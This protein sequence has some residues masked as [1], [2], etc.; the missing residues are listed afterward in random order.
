[1]KYDELYA[2][3]R[4]RGVLWPTA[5]IYGGTQGLYDYG[6]A[7]AR[8]KRQVEEA[9]AAWFLGLSDDFYR[10]DPAEIL[11]EAVV[12][13]SGHL[14]NF[15]DPEVSCAKCGNHFRAETILEKWR[16]EGVDGLSPAQIGELLRQFPVRCPQCGSTELSIPRPFNLMFGFDFGA[17]GGEHAYL[18]PE[19]AQSS[20]LSFSRMWDVGRH[21][22]PLGIAVIGKAYRNEIAPRQV[23]FRMRAFTQAELQIFFNPAS[24]PLPF[25]AVEGEQLP[26]LRAPRRTA[27]EETPE[28]R[29]ARSLV[30]EGLPEF[31]VYF[32]VHLYRFFRDVLG[33]PADRIR[34]F[35]KSDT[36]RAFYNRIQF[37]FEVK[38]ESLGGYKELGAVHYRGDYDLTRHSAGSGKDLSVTLAGGERLV[39]HVLE[40]TFGV[41]RNVWA[42]ADLGLA[43]DGDRTVWRLPSYLAPSTV[44]VFPLI[45]KEH[46]VEA[47][48]W[49][50]RLRKAGI[51]AEFDT[52]GSIGR[53]Y[54]RM[55]ELGVPYC[56]TLDRESL[57]AP[58]PEARTATLRDRDSKAQERVA[59]DAL[60]ARLQASRVVPRPTPLNA[61]D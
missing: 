9:W 61:A 4:R 3:L 45:K 28:M 49:V 27:G 59:L 18:R 14:E 34:L 2:L 33:Y 1:M 51:E 39:P 21:A 8:V 54:A 37:D 15:T 24:F 30:D 23:L 41:D 43:V 55:D 12:R 7:G 20:Y 25:T 47:R 60:V 13:A 40:I 5:E 58:A 53:R 46:T 32:L 17:A 44:G 38:L 35:E 6:P 57:E 19:T 42:L 10:I 26:A 56:V 52:G 48:R 50:E 29:S 22:L 11:P 31:Y 36:E 16:P